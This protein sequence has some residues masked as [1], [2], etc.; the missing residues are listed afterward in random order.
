MQESIAVHGFDQIP[1][2]SNHSNSENFALTV[3]YCLKHVSPQHLLGFMQ[4]PWRPTLPLFRQ[5]H[6]QAIEQVEQ[7]MVQ[8]AAGQEVKP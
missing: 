1:T 6:L 7:A 5:H 4:T 2:A 3:A 8:L